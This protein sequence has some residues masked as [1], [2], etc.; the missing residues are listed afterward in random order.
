MEKRQHA[1]TNKKNFHSVEETSDFQNNR[2]AKLPY[3]QLPNFKIENLPY[4]EYV[5]NKAVYMA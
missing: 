1:V 2:L 3:M 5:T 4:S